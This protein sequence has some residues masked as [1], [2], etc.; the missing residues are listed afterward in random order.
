MCMCY[1]Q[2]QIFQMTICSS[3]WMI[4]IFQTAK[5]VV[6]VTELFHPRYSTQFDL[7]DELETENETIC[8]SDKTLEYV[9]TCCHSNHFLQYRQSKCSGRT[10]WHDKILND[11]WIS[12][13]SG[14][15]DGTFKN[16]HVTSLLLSFRNKTNS[17]IKLERRI[18]VVL[19]C[20]VRYGNHL[21]MHEHQIEFFS[22]VL[23]IIVEK[24]STKSFCS[25]RRTI[26]LNW[27]C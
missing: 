19:Y 11:T 24:I 27:T 17:F 15:E 9:V 13:P 22:F 1:R 4:L 26:D 14:S 3:V 5:L 10:P 8:A 6:P 18:C 7:N 12:I 2:L 25:K 23:S 16:R 20:V 21:M